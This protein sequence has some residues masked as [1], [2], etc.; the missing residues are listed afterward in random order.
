[1]DPRE[2]LA[3]L[4]LVLVA[5]ERRREVVDAVWSSANEGEALERL[6]ELLGVQGDVL[7]QVILDLQIHHMT[8]EK[9]E[10]IATEINQIRHLAEGSPGD[11]T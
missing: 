3:I 5:A 4:E 8:K 7:P 2:H 1:M 10:A 6:R 9:R 11:M